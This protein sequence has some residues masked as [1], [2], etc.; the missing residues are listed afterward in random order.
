MH[1]P[2]ALT[3]TFHILI[4]YSQLFCISKLE[5]YLYLSFSQSSQLLSLALFRFPRCV[6]LLRN[7][8]GYIFQYTYGYGYVCLYLYITLSLSF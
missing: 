8:L 2:R 4:S 6:A 7:D 5:P 3:I 1:S